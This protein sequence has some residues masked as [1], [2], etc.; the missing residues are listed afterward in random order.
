MLDDR[1]W[2]VTCVDPLYCLGNKLQHS[3]DPNLN[4]SH[5]R[6][7]CFVEQSEILLMTRIDHKSHCV[8]YR[9]KSL[10]LMCRDRD[11]SVGIASRYG[12]EG[13]G[14]ESRLRRDFPHLSKPV[15]G[16]TQPPVKWVPG[17]SW[18]K[19]GQAVTLTT[20]PYLLPRS[21]KSRAIPLFPL[22]VLVACYK[23]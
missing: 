4:V 18:G 19:G 5:I 12:L 16:P 7:A 2:S 21:R 6:A 14:I 23:V 10:Y 1:M 11:S 20:H 17:L 8:Q 3:V 15:L 22:W 13:P 9:F